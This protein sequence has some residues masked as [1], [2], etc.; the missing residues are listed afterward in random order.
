MR[1]GPC[2]C[3]LLLLSAM[4][5]RHALAQDG[6][7]CALLEDDRKRLDCYDGLFARPIDEAQAAVRSKTIS[8]AGRGRWSVAEELSPIDDS[9]N[10][11]LTVDSFE[12]VEGRERA[13]LSI[14]CTEGNTAVR[15]SFGGKRMADFEDWGRVTYRIDKTQAF[16][17]S[18][19][20]STDHRSLVFADP[21][22][23]I[24]FSKMLFGAKTLVVRATPFGEL[25]TTVSFPVTGL[26]ETIEPL[27]K[28]CKW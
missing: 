3:A 27:R 8:A 11:Q 16:A 10:V 18:M 21:D 1:L 19:S 26:T 12:A 28:A 14:A 13:R 5:V 15:V 6:S 22:T 25:E 17:T 23:A 7:I 20:S 2:A 24:A 4:T 9:L